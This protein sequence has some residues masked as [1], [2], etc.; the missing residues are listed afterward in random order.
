MG[1]PLL[2]VENH[3]SV[4]EF[5]FHVLQGYEGGVAQTAQQEFRVADGRRSPYDAWSG[6][7]T[8]TEYI[9]KNTMDRTRAA[10]AVFLDRGYVCPRL[11][12]EV[13]DDDFGTTQTVFDIT[14]P[15]ISSTGSVD[16]SMGVRTEEG[17]WL[18]RFPVRSARY[19]R[20]RIPP[21]G[22]GLKPSIVGL[23][24]GLAWAPGA[25]RRPFAPDRNALMV[26]EVS[27]DSGWLGRGRATPRREGV[28]NFKMTTEYDYAL[29]RYH[30]SLFDAGKS[31]IIIPD[32]EQAERAFAA[33]RLQ[34]AHGLGR[35]PDY[36]Y[37]QGELP[38]VEWEPRRR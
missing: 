27:S 6:V 38:Y 33:V 7:G 24:V 32:T 14:L 19:E 26:Q 5:P 36:F 22:A 9:L 13:S 30:I 1:E 37:E 15:T 18:K 21:M 20:F 34:P 4:A 28:M 16:D 31:I 10:N 17:C 11:I 25:L 29:G 2:L 35:D 23:K 3:L 12:Y 8:N